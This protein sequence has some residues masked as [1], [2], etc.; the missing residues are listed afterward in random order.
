MA[1]RGSQTLY[2][3]S[4][5]SLRLRSKWVTQDQTDY[6]IATHVSPYKLC[7]LCVQEEKHVIKT[8]HNVRYFSVV[9]KSLF[10]LCKVVEV[11]NEAASNFITVSK[12][13]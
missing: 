6:S 7:H 2:N 12:S 5:S 13:M 3:E 8:P 10:Y 1:T 4:N 9:D 11:R